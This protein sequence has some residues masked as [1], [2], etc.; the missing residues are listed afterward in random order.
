MKNYFFIIAL[1]ATVH[2]NAQELFVYTEPA[3][4]M[5]A[6]TIG[7]RLSQYFMP[8]KYD[9]TTI[10]HL[11]PE[12]MFGINKNLMVH[13]EG[14]LSNRN[15][16]LAY[17]GFSLYGKYRFFSKDDVHTHF[18]MAGFA[19]ISYNNS[20]IHQDVIDINGHN[21]GYNLGIIATQLLH[22]VALSSSISYIRATDNG[23]NNKYP[24]S[25]ANDGVN[26]TVS[27][28][29]LLLPKEYTNYNQTNL[30]FML[31]FL[32]QKLVGNN[33]SYLD[34]APSLQLIIHSQT[35][36]DIGYRQELYSNLLRT[37]PNGFQIR[38]EHLLFNVFK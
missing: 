1:L 31:E 3:S 21:S 26:Y 20:D 17:E 28:G 36:V 19:K 15:R 12:I 11:L 38:V 4:N 2:S 32:G 30:N 29:K 16:S 22:K 5:P 37:A 27:F 10:Y 25:Q 18:R 9:G 13:I 8:N 35:R 14:F 6:K 24:F 34:I 33:K 7:L 23:S